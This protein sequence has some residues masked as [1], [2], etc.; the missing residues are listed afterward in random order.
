MTNKT[1]L[2]KIQELGKEKKTETMTF[3]FSKR[4]KMKL[5]NT[6]KELNTTSS[7]LLR[8]QIEALRVA[9]RKVQ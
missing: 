5:V 3:R 7:T 9:K 6:A 8:A 2:K 1:L 4:E